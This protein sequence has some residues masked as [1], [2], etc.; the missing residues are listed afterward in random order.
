MT[1]QS[2]VRT[3]GRR[4]LFLEP[5]L[6]GSHEAFLAAWKRHSRH[7]I[8]V[9][10]LAPRHWRWRMES[11]A[12]ELGRRLTGAAQPDLIAVSDYVDLPRLMGFLPPELRG[13]PTLAY[14]HENQLTYEHRE[15]EAPAIPADA[16]AGFANVLTA[17]RADVLVF[18]SEHHRADFSAAADR[19]L[20]TLPKPN[21][22]AELA[23]AAARAHVIAP[24]PEL[25][26]VPLGVGN[27]NGAPLRV[28][29]PHRL[30]PDKDPMTFAR[31]V[32]AA[33]ERGASI[34]VV[35]TGADPERA[36]GDQRAAL[37]LLGPHLALQGHAD[38][39]E[40]LDRLGRCDLVA[41]TA[42][43]EFFGVA[44]AEAMASGCTPLLPDRLNYPALVAHLADT[45][46]VGGLWPDEAALIQA[47]LAAAS[48]PSRFRD[49]A[50]RSRVREAVLHLDA[51][52][53]AES[54]DQ[55]VDDATGAPY[56]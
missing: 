36:R 33:A 28:A 6:G 37:E 5:W 40:Y 48:D 21:P 47:L 35:L 53:C 34:E 51:R 12:W 29:F 8:E 42:H 25:V 7:E 15:G 13:C 24:G 2:R 1:D 18:N 19:F 23:A 20:R 56:R 22:R 30:E 43:H 10:G 3:E 4:L 14:F 44:V 39:R 55:L 17:V 38:R 45:P 27:G 9:L 54:L 31:A 52:R 26:E 49:R 41:S 32:R 50:H 46:A 16:G 11:S